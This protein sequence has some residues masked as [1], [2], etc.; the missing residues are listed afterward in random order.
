MDRAEIQSMSLPRLEARFAPSTWN[1]DTRTVELSWGR[2]VEVERFD[3]RTDLRYIERLTMDP[4]AVD[5]SR[6]NAGAP[7]LDTHG[8]W[9][10]DD[11][12]GAVERAWI[13]NGEGRAVV[14]FSAREDVAPVLRDVQDGILR[15]VSVGYV[16]DDWQESR[17]E[18]GRVVRT[19]LR[20]TPHEISLVP[21]PADASAQ[22]RAAG[23][24]LAS[25]SGGADSRE[26]RMADTTNEPATSPVD[27]ATIRAAAAEAERARIASLDAPLA[28]ARALGLNETALVALRGRAIEEGMDAEAFQTLLFDA[29]VKSRAVDEEARAAERSMPGFQPQ[30][31]SQYGHSWE[32]P[33]IVIDA[34]ATAIAAREMSAIRNKLGDG[35]WRDYAGMRPSD[36]LI[37]LA[38]V[39]GENVTVRDR[40]RLISRAF[41]STSDFPLL[42]ANAGNKMLEAGYAL[43]SPSYRR[44]FARRRFNDF[45]PHS[46]LSVGDFPGLV[47][48]RPGGEITRGTISEKREL[49]S[50]KSY[51]RGVAI[52]REALVNDDLGA[53][54]DFASLIGR[55]VADW[56]NATAYALVNLASGDGPT[57]AE[58]N[59]PVFGTGA[60]RNNKAATA[61]TVTASSLGAGF[62]AIK[63]QTSLDGLKLNLEPR[64]LVCSPV[65]EFVA[66]QFASSSV[67]PSSAGN[68][69]V[70]AARF[71]VV[72]D[73]NIP[74]NRWY[75]FADPASAPVYVHGYVGDAEAP[76]IRVG[77]PLGV[78]GTIIE[79]VHDFAVGAIDYRGG[80]FNPGVAP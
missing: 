64:F 21:I 33:S 2:G 15:N 42:L 32:D 1:P 9:S 65:Q 16:V 66:A 25:S 74:A 59:A 47:E 8:R 30:P 54:T 50:A 26:G 46:F 48:L 70:F 7:L 51:A 20:W 67:V 41:H 27:E 45:K 56:E 17:D 31:V 61:T 14:R 72:S 12:I 5:L 3:W 28:K 10:L 4:S 19:A 11:V 39:R 23:G 6:L 76:S 80:W 57:L 38:R 77:Q 55:R 29:L 53:F 37:E 52:T 73:S 24:A 18:K 60:G 68:V 36:M 69:N 13:E 58:G 71:E 22:V 44:F 35:K 63:N 78:D 75:L 40:M 34:M 62:N 43:A 79:V 49:I